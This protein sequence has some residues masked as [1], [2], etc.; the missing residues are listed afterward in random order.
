[1]NSYTHFF[2]DSKNRVE[3]EIIMSESVKTIIKYEYDSEDRVIRTISPLKVVNYEY[4]SDGNL[5]REY[6][7]FYDGTFTD[8][9]YSYDEKGNMISMWDNLGNKI[10]YNYESVGY[11]C[12]NFVCNNE[13]CSDFSNVESTC[14]YDRLKSK[15][16]GAYTTEVNYSDEEDFLAYN[17]YFSGD[18]YAPYAP[19]EKYNSETGLLE[20]DDYLVYAYGGEYEL[21][22]VTARGDQ[23]SFVSLDY[24]SDGGLATIDYGDN[25]VEGY[26]YEPLGRETA[27]KYCYSGSCSFQ[28]PLIGAILPF[29]FKITGNAIGDS[30]Y[31]MMYSLEPGDSEGFVTKSEF[32]SA[33]EKYELENGEIVEYDYEPCDSSFEFSEYSYCSDENSLSEY[34]C[35]RKSLFNSELIVKPSASNCEFGCEFGACLKESTINQ[36]VNETAPDC[37]DS[38]GGFDYYIY[39][40]TTHIPTGQLIEEDYCDN[41]VTLVE[42]ACFVGQGYGKSYIYYDCP[43]GCVNG[44][45]VETEVPVLDLPPEPEN[46]E[47]V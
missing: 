9:S 43:N 16:I 45:C 47:R 13:D 20:E 8:V 17:S 31:I 3:S 7:A 18:P 37:F 19:L 22:R 4:D 21:E 1:M 15:T 11:P 35:G 29:I 12:T 25:L 23:E 41:N 34:Y 33:I 24:Y 36:T 10:D 30:G 14:S 44:V 26:Y 38:D 32:D 28:F 2:Y 42:Q 27:Y 40:N 6:S 5:V 46:P 39:G